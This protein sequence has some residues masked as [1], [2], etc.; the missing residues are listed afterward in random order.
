MGME[1]APQKR[2]VDIMGAL[3]GFGLS[4]PIL[5]PAMVAIRLTM[6]SPVLFRQPRCGQGE[7]V[8]TLIKLRTMS[9]TR[10]SAGQLLPPR[11][12]VTPLGRI[13]RRLS[14]D[15][16]PQLWNVLKGDMS[17]VGP[18]PLPLRYLPWYTPR[19]RKRHLARPGITGLAQVSGR[20]ALRWEDRLELDVQYV[21]R[22]TLAFDL[23]ILLTTFRSVLSGEGQDYP[24]HVTRNLV[25]YRRAMSD[26]GDGNVLSQV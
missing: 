23:R 21:E 20:N 11:E 15:E 3:I 17:L 9:E 22:R 10:D 1:K 19:E 5:L 8:F 26:E 12:R 4:T 6:G 18:R 16:L 24:D 13:L 14:V 2:V 25:E 7:R